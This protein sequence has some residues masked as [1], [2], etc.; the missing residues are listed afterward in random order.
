[1]Q[2][3]DHDVLIL[4]KNKETSVPPLSPP[5]PQDM[6]IFDVDFPF[7]NNAQD[8]HRTNT[9]TP[10]HSG[11]ETNA[12]STPDPTPTPTQPARTNNKR[13][14]PLVTEQIATVSRP[15]RNRK[16]KDYGEDYVAWFFFF[17]TFSF[18]LYIWLYCS[19][20]CTMMVISDG[21]NTA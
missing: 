3:N 5:I 2:C 12:A 19:S 16:A 21:E 17:R 15:T 7:D 8:V 14:A 9:D 6:N 18:F 20:L 1:M 11:M 13:K 4:P 10:S